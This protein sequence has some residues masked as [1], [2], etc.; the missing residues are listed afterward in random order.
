MNIKE[1]RAH[2]EA[3]GFTPRE[4]VRWLAPKALARTAVKAVLADIFADYADKREIQGTLGAELLR[5]PLDDPGAEETWIDFVAD[6]GDGFD[7][8]ASVA[9]ALAAKELTVR[10][11]NCRTGPAK[12]PDTPLPR[13]SLLVLG[14]DEVYPVGSVGA[15]RDRMT[16]P[17]ACALPSAADGTP[18][19]LAL[20]GN[21]DWYDGLTAFL[22]TFTRQQRIG[23]WQ[24]RQTRSYFVVK[25]PRHWWL[26]GLDSQLGSYLDAP[27]LRYFQD[28]LSAHLRP[29]DGVIV[30]CADPAWVKSADSDVN[31]FNTLHWFDRTVVRTRTDPRT[32]ERV[33]TDASIRLWLTGDKHHYARYTEHLPEDPPDCVDPPP[34]TR[35]RQ[36]VT[37]GL[38]GAFLSST[39]RLPRTLRLPPPGTRLRE[40]DDPPATFTHARETTYPDVRRSR[41][42]AR[43]I[44][45]PWSRYWLPLRNPGF[46][47]LSAA[48]HTAAF[49]VLAFLF[50]VEEGRLQPIDA[51]RRADAAALGRFL[52]AA[53]VVVAVVVALLLIGSIVRGAA[54]LRPHRPREPHA[55]ARARLTGAV[56]LQAL[57]GLA[58]LAVVVAL[59][60][61][62]SWSGWAV[63]AVC[64]VVAAALGGALGSEAFAVWVLSAR[65][66]TVAD[67]QMS[68]QAVEDHKGFLRLYIAPD[69]DITLYPLVIDAVCRQWELAGAPAGGKRAVPA[70]PLAVRLIEDPVVIAREA[71]PQ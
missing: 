10:P 35:R 60:F 9:S 62:A 18:L 44:A 58:I 23:G 7:A 48:V 31:A 25:L 24:T 49:L 65:G 4:Q 43:R 63:L 67:W 28:H 37:C 68:G 14:G 22:R 8:T 57:V 12:R 47:Q 69:G 2:A 16:G 20:P 11:P 26:V 17:Y 15:Y 13:G 21:H 61:P 70:E 19:M 36:M 5:A 38:G 53:A 30:C 55:A 59:P 56:L 71:K 32:G 51:V 1:L 29:G 33:P 27:Q 66:G 64:L 50:A 34:D 39:H 40:K 41:R 6:L 54:A 42:F 3:L 52:G 46:W 45:L